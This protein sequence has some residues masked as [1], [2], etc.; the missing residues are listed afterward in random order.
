MTHATTTCQS[1]MCVNHPTQLM[2][3]GIAMG[4]PSRTRHAEVLCPWQAGGNS[5][6]TAHHLQEVVHA[7]AQPQS[8]MGSCSVALQCSWLGLSPDVSADCRRC[9]HKEAKQAC[10]THMRVTSGLVHKWETPWAAGA[11]SSWEKLG[12]AHKQWW[13]GTGAATTQPQA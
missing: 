13:V 9:Q 4:V 3:P 7:T 1:N 8:H 10:Q 6:L 11:A 12:S 2:V 5:H